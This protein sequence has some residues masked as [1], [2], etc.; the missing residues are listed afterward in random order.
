MNKLV[1]SYDER[2]KIPEAK[3]IYAFYLD[4]SYLKRLTET[5]GKIDARSALQKCVRAHRMSNPPQVHLALHKMAGKYHSSFSIDAKHAI[6]INETA[7]RK[8]Q[9]L[10]IV[11]SALEQC[12]FL[13]SPIYIGITN[14]QTFRSRYGQH[15]KVY[16]EALAEQLDEPPPNGPDPMVFGGKFGDKLAKRRIEF[17]DLLFV[18]I[19]LDQKQMKEIRNIERFLHVIVNPV[20]SER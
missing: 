19:P 16:R 9:S 4:L 2:R 17:R 7:L 15:Y 5:P 12:T 1:F 13:T 18:C 20:L 10:G 11:A 3:G 14:Q 8:K 6:G